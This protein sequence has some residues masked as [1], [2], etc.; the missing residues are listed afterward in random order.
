MGSADYAKNNTDAAYSWIPQTRPVPWLFT[1]KRLAGVYCDVKSSEEETLEAQNTVSRV[2][3]K[4]LSLEVTNL[5]TH[6]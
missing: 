6:D 2:L 3:V 5:G 4:E 1:E